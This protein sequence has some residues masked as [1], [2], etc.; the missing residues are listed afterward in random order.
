LDINIESL[1]T[2][3]TVI[4]NSIQ[5]SDFT[6]TDLLQKLDKNVFANS[7]KVMQLALTLPIS[8]ATCE[9]SFSVKRRIHAN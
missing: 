5:N 6:L 9:R 8:S 3:M 2:E 7:Y 4:K 1:K